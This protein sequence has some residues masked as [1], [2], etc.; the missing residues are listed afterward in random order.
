MRAMVR[1]QSGI[2]VPGSTS[3]CDIS[4]R[5]QQTRALCNRS[6]RGSEERLI[7]VR[8][9]RSCDFTD[10]LRCMHCAHRQNRTTI[11]WL[12]RVLE[13][14]I[15]P[16]DGRRMLRMGMRCEG[17]ARG[18]GEYAEYVFGLFNSPTNCQAQGC[19]DGVSKSRWLPDRRDCKS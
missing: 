16:Y 6:Q 9:L 5:S 14:V 19:D 18:N 2:V 7:S 1:E 17:D 15:M 13:P 3:S 11:V 8:H 12:P 4:R 10:F